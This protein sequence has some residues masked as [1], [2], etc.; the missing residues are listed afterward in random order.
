MNDEVK[1]Q[2]SEGE[3]KRRALELKG[4]KKRMKA[5]ASTTWKKQGKKKR[6]R[7]KKSLSS[8]RMQFDNANHRCYGEEESIREKRG[9]FNSKKEARKRAEANRK[10]GRRRDDFPSSR[11]KD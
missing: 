8:C 1:R 6:M 2:K 9:K 4:P 3:K 10:L 11:K 5:V 7:K